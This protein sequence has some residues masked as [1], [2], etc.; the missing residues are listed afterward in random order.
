MGSYINQTRLHQRTNRPN[1]VPRVVLGS[2]SRYKPQHALFE[3][4]VEEDPQ[5]LLTTFLL[6]F[7]QKRRNK[8]SRCISTWPCE[9][10]M[11]APK[12][13]DLESKNSMVKPL[14]DENLFLV[15][16]AAKAN[17]LTKYQ[18][19]SCVLYLLYP[20]LFM[21]LREFESTVNSYFKS[22][23]IFFPIS[24]TSVNLIGKLS[25]NLCGLKAAISTRTMQAPT[26][27]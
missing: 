19:W 27:K 6:N 17:W 26:I 22:D 1:K 16:Y 18:T 8:N 9:G 12:G 4:P 20:Q 5:S 3:L 15:E 13:K 10:I 2:F 7:E 24:S 25:V 14:L 23:Y 21:G 11:K